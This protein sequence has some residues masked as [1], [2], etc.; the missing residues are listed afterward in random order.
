MDTI[1]KLLK[2]PAPKRKSRAEMLAAASA[3]E[4]A[5]AAASYYGDEAGDEERTE[6]A[7]PLFVRWINNASGSRLGVPTA[8]LDGPIGETLSV[9]W[10]RPERNILVEEV[11]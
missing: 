3:A 1:N 6:T 7:N 5:S 8:W 10:K 2:K 9:G 11:G 4:S